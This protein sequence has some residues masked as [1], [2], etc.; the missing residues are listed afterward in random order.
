MKTKTYKET[1]NIIGDIHGRSS[2]KELV[3][4]SR[5]N[6]FLGDYFDPYDDM[7]FEDIKN[8]FLDIVQFTKI[9]PDTI[10]LLGNHDLHYIHYCDSSRMDYEHTGII[11]SLFIDNIHMFKGVAHNI[12]DSIL[13][14]HAGFTRD[15][16]ELTRYAGSGGAR[17]YVDHA[18]SLFWGGYNGVRW[19][20]PRVSLHEFTFGA[21]AK[22]S[23]YYGVSPG[24]SPVWVRP[25]TLHECGVN[26]VDQVV[27]H[28]QVKI[29]VE[30]IGEN[31]FPGSDKQLVLCD[32]LGSTCASLHIDY[33]SDDDYIYSINNTHE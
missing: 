15:W 29:I 7:S 10:L 21:H 6:I 32:C 14:S 1:Y 27:G 25:A 30:N 2:W 18:N 23:D 17:S 16:C 22:M 5:I 3:D 12:G 31:N 28:T 19:E 33:N 9:H 13:I 8:N 4:P 24:Q 11:E 20:N 26:D